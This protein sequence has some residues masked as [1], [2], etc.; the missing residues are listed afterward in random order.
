METTGFSLATCLSPCRSAGNALIAVT[1]MLISAASIAHGDIR[2]TV[3][4]T[5]ATSTNGND[6]QSST[7]TVTV[8]GKGKFARVD[9]GGGRS[10][11]FDGVA[12]KVIVFE[13]GNMTYYSVSLKD[14]QATGKTAKPDPRRKFD[15][16]S[17][18][19]AADDVPGNNRIIDGIATRKYLLLGSTTAQMQGPGQRGPGGPGGGMGGPPGG[20]GGMGG[21]GW[22]VPGG[23]M[24]LQGQGGGDEG[25]PM[26]FGPKREMSVSGEIWLAQSKEFSTDARNIL[27]ADAFAS[28]W[29]LAEMT[30]PVARQ[31]QK[32]NGLPLRAKFS[33]TRPG[34]TENENTVNVDVRTSGLTLDP[35]PDSLFSVPPTYTQVVVP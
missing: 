16:D 10:T 26:S 18:F 27:L 31:L 14:W 15:I 11:L 8:Y 3:N 1:A 22:G 4:V 21:G 23:V 28:Q 19:D 24:R 32:Q 30:A 12:N 29:S 34:R 9:E 35:L 17:S 13:P 33:V 7:K 5:V 25:F 6:I 2:V 20:G